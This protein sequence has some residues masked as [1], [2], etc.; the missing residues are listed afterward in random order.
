MSHLESGVK[1][2]PMDEDPQVENVEIEVKENWMINLKPLHP[3]Q[4]ILLDLTSKEV[5][6]TVNIDLHSISSRPTALKAK[7]ELKETYFLWYCTAVCILRISH[8]KVFPNQEFLNT[9]L[10]C[11]LLKEEPRWCN[12]GSAKWFQRQEISCYF[13]CHGSRWT[14]RHWAANIPGAQPCHSKL[15]SVARFTV[16]CQPH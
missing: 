6:V 9:H 13:L 4:L 7:L 12:M 10:Q 14:S 3:S 11:S 8:Q 5:F 15:L 2:D 1:N 16:K